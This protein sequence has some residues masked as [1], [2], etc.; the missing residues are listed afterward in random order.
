MAAAPIVT[1]VMGVSASGKST[2]GARLA[3]CL[4]AEFIDGDDLH[5]EANVRKMAAGQPLDDDDRAPW[6]AAIRECLQQRR[7][8]GTGIVVACSSLKASY[9]D[10][11]RSGNDDLRF[12]F[13]D[14][15]R[16][17]VERRITD[18]A[19]HFMKVD[20]VASQFEALE[21]PT[22]EPDVMTLD[23]EKPVETLLEDYLSAAKQL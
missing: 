3:K 17:S 22:E 9:R 23:G 10:A 21:R 19:G 6:L 7:R 18:R 4:D 15:R 5:P 8:A 13:L 11:L 14:V 16:Q 2:F 12:V 1:I 20:M